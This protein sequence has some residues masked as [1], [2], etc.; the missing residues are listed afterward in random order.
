MNFKSG[1]SSCIDLYFNLGLSTFEMEF[2]TERECDTYI[3]NETL[4]SLFI[5]EITGDKEYSNFEL[6]KNFTKLMQP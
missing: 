6:A 2:E 4:K 1:K 5:K 3:F